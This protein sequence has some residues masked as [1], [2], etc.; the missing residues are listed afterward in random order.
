MHIEPGTL[1]AAKLAFVN[2][3]VV[4]VLAAHAPTW[5]RRPSLWLRTVLAALFFTLC[6]QAFHMQIGVRE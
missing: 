3:A 1:N 4:A 6:M 2:V 5:L